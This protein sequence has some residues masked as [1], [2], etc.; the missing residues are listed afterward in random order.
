MKKRSLTISIIILVLI[1]M[2]AVFIIL[3]G[4]N[5]NSQN[6]ISGN[7]D[8]NISFILNH[9]L[10]DEYHAEA[11]YKKIIEDFGEQRPYINIVRAEKRHSQAIENLYRNYNLL[12]PDNEWEDDEKIPSFNSLQEACQASAQAE[13]DNIDLY[14]ELLPVIKETDIKTVFTNNRDASKDKHLPAFNKCS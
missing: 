14:E 8:Y 2:G 10:Q 11:I 5:N 9:T 3:K 13:I 7:S 1:I 6:N 12:I 4:I